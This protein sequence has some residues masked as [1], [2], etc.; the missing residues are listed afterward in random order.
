MPQAIASELLQKDFVD[1]Y[2]RNR[3]R[4]SALFDLLSPEAYTS[5]P[6]P[7]RHPICFYEGHLPAFSYI[8]LIERTL[9]GGPI[10]AY[11]EKLF[12]RGI[13]PDDA[14]AAA[15][16]AP[17]KWPSRREI[18]EFAKRCDDAVLRELGNRRSAR[19]ERYLQ[20]A[21]TILEHEQMHHETLVYIL[22]R[23][24]YAQKPKPL[25]ASTPAD[26]PLP[27]HELLSIPAGE[28]LLGANRGEIPFGWDNEFGASVCAV[29]A[30]AI[31]KHSVTNADYLRFVDAGGEPPPFWVQRNGR[32]FQQ[33]MFEEVE[34]PLSWPVYVTY[35][36]A[37]A[38]ARW[39]GLGLP[40]E[41]QYQRAAYGTPQ[42]SQRLFP[43][44][45]EAPLH[46]HGNF[47]FQ[48]WDPRPAGSF[49][50]GAS[51]WGV[52]DLVGNG[53]EWTSSR[54]EPFPGFTPMASYPQYSADF[55][56]GKHY[57]LKGASPVTA[58]ELIRR[59][60]RNWFR[61]NYPYIYAKFRCVSQ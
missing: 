27:Q 61:P 49:P 46:K 33:A 24:P 7:L 16:S 3:S 41:A 54:F 48:Q 17:P 40:T 18:Q 60:L 32:W 25:D 43:W 1:W 51:A 57:V 47:D 9:G 44:G 6:I 15:A 36:Q 2:R 45:S 39:K 4:S 53:W 5:R 55:F 31:D 30:F 38:Y 34:L 11:L 10:D 22:Q 28:A 13:D 26:G 56:D 21:Y 42:G 14:S 8:T 35:D 29:D 58:R 19:D 12:Q 50:D 52:Q 37:A 20:A 59:S 23:V